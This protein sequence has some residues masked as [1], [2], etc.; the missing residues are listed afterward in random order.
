MATNLRLRP[1]TE[2]ALRAESL[3]TGR[4]QQDLIREA[5]DRYLG[6]QSPTTGSS[7]T[8]VTLG[9]ARP[10]RPFLPEPAHRIRLPEGMTAADLLDRDDRL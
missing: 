10:P 2:S 4:S 8:L 3:R 7:P 5:L 6:H 9:M 1:E